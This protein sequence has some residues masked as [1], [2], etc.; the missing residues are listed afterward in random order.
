MTQKSRFVF[1]SVAAKFTFK[2]YFFHCVHFW[3]ASLNISDLQK[4]TR[5]AGGY[6]SVSPSIRRLWAILKTFNQKELEKFLQ[7]VTSCERAP[8]LGFSQLEPPF[9]VQWVPDTNRLPSASTC[10]NTLK[11]PDYGNQSI[12]RK[13]LMYVI[14]SNAGFGLTWETKHM[15]GG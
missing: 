6:S 15:R 12:L 9:C 5:Y 11:I 2:G 1:V 10:F 4:Y 14:N 8:P 13:K 7:F 3:Y